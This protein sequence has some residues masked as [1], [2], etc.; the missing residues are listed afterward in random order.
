MRYFSILVV[1]SLF[2]ST[3][4]AQEYEGRLLYKQT[5]AGQESLVTV[6]VR[7][8]QALIQRGN[9]KPIFY[10][11][12]AESPLFQAWTQGAVKSDEGKLATL[13]MVKPLKAAGTEQIIAGFKAKPFKLE[14]ANGQLISGWYAPTVAFDHNHFLARIQGAEWAQL[15]G[16]GLLLRWEVSSAKG[17]KMLTGE[18]IDYQA[19]KQDPSL[20]QAPRLTAH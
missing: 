14:L 17:G 11:V 18:L 3:A 5:I 19:G 12:S 16:K 7:P 20:F 8:Q 13:S 4:F 2:L 15:P 9:D 1:W 10:L 6:Y